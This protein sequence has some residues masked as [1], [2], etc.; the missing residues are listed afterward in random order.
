VPQIKKRR[1]ILGIKETTAVNQRNGRPPAAHPL[2]CLGVSSFLTPNPSPL[3]YSFISSLRSFLAAAAA[4][5]AELDGSSDDDEGAAALIDDGDEGLVRV[6]QLAEEQDTQP[7]AEVWVLA[8]SL[9]IDLSCGLVPLAPTFGIQGDAFLRGD[10]PRAIFRAAAGLC[11]PVFLPA[12]SGCDET[13][14]C[15]CQHD[16]VAPPAAHCVVQPRF[17][18]TFP[19]CSRLRPSFGCFPTPLPPSTPST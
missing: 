11:A 2:S 3:P 16:I 15:A 10:I 19:F 1:E 14:A 7:V 17:P 6:P 12:S 13:P 5:K 8:M 4:A 9:C 18:M